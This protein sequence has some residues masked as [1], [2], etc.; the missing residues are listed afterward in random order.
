MRAYWNKR[1]VN[2]L[3]LITIRERATV[4]RVFSRFPFPKEVTTVTPFVKMMPLL[5]G[6]LVFV[7][8][9]SL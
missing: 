3:I 1:Y 6:T 9:G 8:V 5:T 7:N 2:N 4:C